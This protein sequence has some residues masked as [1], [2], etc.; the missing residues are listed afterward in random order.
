MDSGQWILGELPVPDAAD[1]R[2][3][4]HQPVAII[5]CLIPGG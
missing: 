3:S 4:I 5:H 1:T 2:D